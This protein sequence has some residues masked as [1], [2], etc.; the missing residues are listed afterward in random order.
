MR[1]SRLL[2]HPTTATQVGER[3]AATGTAARAA[4]V[5]ASGWFGQLDVGDP[6]W[7]DAEPLLDD[8]LRAT[9]R[10][11]DG[12]PLVVKLRTLGRGLGVTADAA[13]VAHVTTAIRG[14]ATG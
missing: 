9:G 6:R 13:V 4:L 7:R 10:T 1:T 3:V 2:D 12:Q 5:E 11:V 8:L 14:I